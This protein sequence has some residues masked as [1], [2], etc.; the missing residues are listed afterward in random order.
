MIY[1]GF[2]EAMAIH[3]AVRRFYAVAQFLRLVHIQASLYN[4]FV[5]TVDVLFDVLHTA[6]TDFNY[7]SS[8]C[9]IR[10]MCFHQKTISRDVNVSKVKGFTY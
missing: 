4:G 6:T 9:Q 10:A 3:G 7:V 5:K 1:N 2:S 8:N